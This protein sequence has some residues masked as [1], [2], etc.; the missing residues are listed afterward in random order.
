MRPALALAVA[1][2]VAFSVV[3]LHTARSGATDSCSQASTPASEGQSSSRRPI[4]FVH[5]W[6]GHGSD[7]IDSAA[8]LV[9]QTDKRIQP[10][11]FDYGKDSI[12]WAGAPAVSGCLAS[13][14]SSVSA[15]YY[16]TG[17]DGKA[18]VAGHSMGGLAALYASTQNNAG[19]D[20]GGLI[21]F[22]TPYAGSPFGNT[23][24]ATLREAILAGV[25]VPPSGSDAGKCLGLHDDGASLP[26]TC[27]WGLPPYL[28]SG[29][30]VDQIAGSIK[31]RRTFLGIHMYDIPFDSD[32]IVS[33]SSSHAYV[34]AGPKGKR[35]PRADVH[36][37]TDECT[38]SSD[39]VV[40]IVRN[41]RWSGELVGLFNTGL[42]SLFNDDFTLDGINSGH[43]N[44]SLAVYLAALEAAAPCSH[45]HVYKDQSAL[46]QATEAIKRDLQLLTPLSAQ[47]LLS[48]PVPAT[49]NH[50]AGLLVNG[51]Q[52]GIPENEGSTEFAWLGSPDA[53][54][55]ELVFG[56][57]E[58]NGRRDAATVLACDA[59]GVAWPEIVV[60][61]GPGP[62]LLG[63]FDLG[64]ISVGGS[65]P[66]E[67]ANVYGLTYDNGRV[68]VTF[69]SQQEGDPAAFASLD[70]RATLSLGRAGH[71]QVTNV[72]R[73]NEEP[74]MRRLIAALHAG[75]HAT[76]SSLAAPGVADQAASVF[77]TYSDAYNAPMTCYGVISTD[78]PPLL[79]PLVDAGSTTEL[80]A[81][82]ICALPIA[83]PDGRSY[84]AL[85]LTHTGYQNW[86]V[87]WVQPI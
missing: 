15:A 83:G 81:D 86:R 71:L 44:P 67:N 37:S 3:P 55:T 54:R 17:G 57:L 13:Y 35:P 21:T 66:G 64:T 59:G 78:M 49:C 20:I 84:V 75:D 1:A 5:G 58:G 34:T 31:V 50:P 11:F 69:A 12:T 23:S 72:Q 70:F 25:D 9:R 43:L 74:T 56:G 36:L 68:D 52:P 6:T 85:G 82:R 26:Q 2:S 8:I 16:K 51:S 48:A 33:T 80:P 7:F 14:I 76:A 65:Q 29:V 39:A 45:G 30:P 41:A 62:T 53:E 18:L 4:I 61:Y 60:F 87:Q 22:D 47:S 27:A 40:G 77:S 38:V 28:P 32:A 73:T 19:P 79:S 46:N 24:V 42:L 63:A 10:F